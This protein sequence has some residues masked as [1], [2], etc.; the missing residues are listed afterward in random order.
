MICSVIS[1]ILTSLSLIF[2]EQ[3]ADLMQTP[4]NIRADAIRYIHII[5]MGMAGSIFYSLFSGILRAVGNTK[6]P[7]LINMISC[8]INISLDMTI[9]PYYH[10]GVTGVAATTVLAQIIA[11]IL[12]GL[13]L[14]RNYK[15]FIPERMDFNPDFTYL[16]SISSIG[17]S[18]AAM[19]CVVDLGNIL[20]QSSNNTLGGKAITAESIATRISGVMMTPIGTLM[21]ACSTFV[22]QNYGAGNRERINNGIRISMILEIIWGCIACTVILIVGKPLFRFMTSTNDKEL[23]DMGYQCLKWC[24]PFFPVLGVLCVIRTV[25][26]ALGSKIIPILSSVIEVASRGWTAFY[27]IPRFGFYGTCIGVPITWTIMAAFLIAS[28]ELQKIKL[29]ANIRQKSFG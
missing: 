6:T 14:F 22:S 19:Y 28:Y 5:F 25:M 20:F 17:L 4:R 26:Q 2:S 8:L 16:R 29:F 24:M 18:M 3:L 9:V 7:L 12:C 13:Y 27:L 1:V 11:A 23:V 10:L 15:I 21:S